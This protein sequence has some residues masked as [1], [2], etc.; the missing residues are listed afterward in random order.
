MNRDAAMAQPAARRILALTVAPLPPLAGAPRALR[1]LPHVL[2]VAAAVLL[3]LAGWPQLENFD[4]LGAATAV[5]VAAADAAALVLAL[6]A[7][8]SACLGSLALCAATA[9][10]LHVTQWLWPAMLAHAGILLLLCLRVR[11]RTTLLA[12]ALTAAVTLALPTAGPGIPESPHHTYRNVALGI[13]TAAA[14]AGALLR[15]RREAHTEALRQATAT[16]DERARRTVLEERTRIA[17]ELHDVIAHHMSVISIQ[18]Q[19]ATRQLKD[20]PPELLDSLAAIR[21]GAVEALGELRRVLAL[22]RAEDTDDETPYTPQPTLAQLDQ[23][24]ETVRATGTT[25]TTENTGTPRPLPPSVELSA[26][27]ITQEALSNALR[28]APG[29]AVHIRL[30]YTSDTLTIQVTNTAPAHPT[31]PVPGAGHGLLGMRERTAMLGGQLTTQPGPGGS[32]T[33]TAVLPAAPA[34]QDQE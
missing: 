27:R 16:A 18:A 11:A 30:D 32:Y 12:W 9:T 4:H 26:Y 13:F 1:Y 14:V 17:R 28:H 33:V 23:L 10:Q 15:S 5:A 19:V 29:A 21:G 34:H 6:Y 22:L 8:G 2:T 31:R 20:P 7:P 25:L 24:T 3:F